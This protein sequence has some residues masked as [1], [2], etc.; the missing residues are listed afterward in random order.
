MDLVK[1][2]TPQNEGGVPEKEKFNFAYCNMTGHH[3]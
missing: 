1:Q 3:F 2:N